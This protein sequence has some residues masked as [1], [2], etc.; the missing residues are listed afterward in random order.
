MIQPIIEVTRV[1]RMIYHPMDGDRDLVED[2]FDRE[3]DLKRDQR[4]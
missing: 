1:E 3:N 4:C 2:V